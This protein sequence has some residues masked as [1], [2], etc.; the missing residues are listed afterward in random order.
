MKK[1][2]LIGTVLP[3]LAGA[4][5]IGAGFSLWFFNDASVEIAQTNVSK[6]VTQ[7]VEI[8]TI[9]TADDFTVV[10]D[11]ATRA[12][13]LVNAG[14]EAKG[15]YLDFGAGTNKVAKYHKPTDEGAVDIIDGSTK[16]V[17]TTEIELTNGLD[18]YVKVSYDSLDLTYDSTSHK[19]SSELDFNPS[20]NEDDMVFNWEK[21]SFTYAE[22]KEPKNKT[23]Y[24]SFKTLVEG[25]TINVKYTAT[26]KGIKA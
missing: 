19:F 21:V 6:N 17:F 2:L 18:S 24:A 11:Q 8:G 16:V 25:S 5:V 26:L 10:F 23:E 22:N 4:A 13:D 12:N 7:L 3:L 1:K 15:I 14:L 20:T 9:T